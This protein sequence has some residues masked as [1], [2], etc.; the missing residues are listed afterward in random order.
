MTACV[1]EATE[2]WRLEVD[3]ILRLSVPLALTQLALVAIVT[4]D[5]VMM[6][7]LGSDSLAAGTLAGHYF[8]IVEFFAFG[9]LGSVAPILSQH[10]GARRF[11]MVRPTVRQGLWAAIIIAGPGAI[12]LWYAGSVLVFLGQDPDLSGA[13]QSYLNYLMIGLLPM[14]GN[15][16]LNEF[17]VAH[18][19]PRA[20]L[21]VSVAAIAVN[22]IADYA[23][24]FGHFGAPAMGLEGA[25]LA[26][27]IVTTLMFLA[28]LAF[29]L[30]D[31][32]LRRY[33]LWGNFWRSDWPQLWEIIT[34]GIPMAMTSV[35]EGGIVLVASLFMG[36]ISVDALA[37]HG[38]TVQCIVFIFI[39]PTGLMQAASVRVGRAV[40]ARDHQAASSAGVTALGLGFA[41]SL[42]IAAA[43]LLFGESIVG[44][45]LDDT[46]AENQMAANLAVS[47]LAVGA[48]FLIADSAQIVAR[49]ALMGLKDTKVPMYI[50]FGSH[51]VSL[52]AA[53]LFGVYLGYGGQAIWLCMLASTAVLAVL[54]V[55]RFQ[56]RCR[57]L[58][59][60]AKA[61]LAT[62]PLSRE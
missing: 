7:W 50:S 28:I 5:V 30:T 17:L 4:T 60:L 19:R 39:V 35:V 13:S 59:E 14:L 31:R 32:R 8:W 1:T 6:G 49:G 42:V 15:I 3:A 54:L 26:S 36:W 16:V 53:G 58:T 61:A 51:G 24:M 38:V 20:T 48:V 33:R 45:Y 43:F 37:A 34:V 29:V 22:G 57:H 52:P 18:A 10:L 56:S 46:V 41:Y 9:L 23:L 25:G 11:R 55:R 44:I 21:V 62:A 27:A 12:L 47:F 40:G 2:P